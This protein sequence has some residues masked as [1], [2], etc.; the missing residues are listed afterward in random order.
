MTSWK[1]MEEKR[2]IKQLRDSEWRLRYRA[3]ITA[4]KVQAAGK[5]PDKK[6]IMERLR[7]I[8]RF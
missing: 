6:G 2:R 4:Q 7:G 1:E 3:K 5:I 8:F